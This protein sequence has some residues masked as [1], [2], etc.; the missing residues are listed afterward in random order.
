MKFYQKLKRMIKFNFY[1]I[2]RLQYYNQ[3]VRKI[4]LLDDEYQVNVFESIIDNSR[5]I[6]NTGGSIWALAFIP[7]TSNITRICKL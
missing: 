2:N 4:A 1:H 6:L 7:Y 5:F 3:E